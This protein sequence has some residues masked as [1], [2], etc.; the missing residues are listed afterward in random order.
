MAAL[1]W[2][3]LYLTKNKKSNDNLS[4]RVYSLPW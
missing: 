4:L 1:I 3:D 2:R